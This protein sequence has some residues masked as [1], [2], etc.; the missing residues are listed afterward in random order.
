MI[1]VE[2]TP[3]EERH[4]A[5]QVDL[6]ARAFTVVAESARPTDSAAW[7]H[8]FHGPANPAGRALIALA[9]EGEQVVGSAS[10]IA[11]RF[12]RPDG[13]VLVGWQVG[14]F[15]VDAAQQRKG[16]GSKL[17]VALTEALE[18]RTDDFVYSYPN[19]RSI[20]VFDRHGYD[21]HGRT[22][23]RIF[24]PAAG[25]GRAWEL[26][27]VE[28]DEAAALA[29]EADGAAAGGTAGEP[30]GFVRDAPYFRWRFCAPEAGDRYR[31]VEARERDGDG[32]FVLALA[33]HRFAGLSFGV[34]ADTCPA[35]SGPRLGVAV[36]AALA[37]GRSAGA[38]LLY[39]TTSLDGDARAPWRVPVPESRDPRPVVLVM[40]RTTDG[41]LA[42]EVATSA[43]ATADWGG[44]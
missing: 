26:R 12:R 24:L 30:S 20:P 18:E 31:F 3:Y 21:R 29:A 11:A 36:R 37:A 4:A 43:V 7:L 42:R 9:R 15:V 6:Q 27:V 32:R 35:L 19:S 39:A 8:H 5:T 28:R 16:I 17:L 41:T 13:R 23:T 14:T 25:P 34:L 10:A 33:S 1:D 40:P 44:F 2:V 22:P 38:W